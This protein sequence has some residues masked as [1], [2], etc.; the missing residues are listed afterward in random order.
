MKIK[1]FVFGINK[2]VNKKKKNSVKNKLTE[3]YLTFNLFLNKNW[4]S[5]IIFFPERIMIV[6]V[7]VLEP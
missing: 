4:I 5:F 3:C 1:T 6:S 2:N 7:R